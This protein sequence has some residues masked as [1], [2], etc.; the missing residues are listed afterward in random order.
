M[1]SNSARAH[2]E[3]VRTVTHALSRREPIPD[4]IAEQLAAL[5]ARN[6]GLQIEIEALAASFPWRPLLGV[7]I[8]ALHHNEARRKLNVLDRLRIS[9]VQDDAIVMSAIRALCSNH[10]P[11]VAFWASF[12]MTRATNWE[13]Q[14]AIAS[15]ARAIVQYDQI[16]PTTSVRHICGEDMTPQEGQLLSESLSQLGAKPI[17]GTYGI[18]HM[19]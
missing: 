19:K 1:N 4:A 10:N 7:L 3:A 18:G 2:G 12:A 14:N 13:D 8:D 15:L 9:A 5:H 17:R 16:D 11:L 6:P